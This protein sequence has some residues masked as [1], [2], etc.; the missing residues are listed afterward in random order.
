MTARVRNTVLAVV[1][2]ALLASGA[3]AL[4]SQAGGGSASAHGAGQP[5]GYATGFERHR[6]HDR[7]AGLGLDALANKLGVS[8]DQL[9]TALQGVR[10]DLAPQRG[11]LATKLADALGV[12]PDK[13]RAAFEKIRT[14]ARKAFVA[15]LA[16]RLNLDQSKVEQALGSLPGPFFG[17][18]HP[19]GGR[20]PPRPAPLSRSP[21]SST[22][23]RRS[24]RPS[25][26]RCASR[27]SPWRRRRVDARRSTP[28]RGARRR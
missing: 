22:T 28:S 3:Y 25:S 20:G 13:V 2:A 14:D 23:R 9:R 17:R 21:S 24:G 10:R 6:F 8:T 12:T 15:A 4:G 26:A 5:S 16:K 27:A 1:G 18:R 7:A 11:D 19:G